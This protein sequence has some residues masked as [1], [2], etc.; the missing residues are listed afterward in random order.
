MARRTAK[1]SLLPLHR[2]DVLG[3]YGKLPKTTSTNSSSREEAGKIFRQITSSLPTRCHHGEAIQDALGPFIYIG[4]GILLVF[5]TLVVACT[6]PNCGLALL[7][8]LVSGG[9]SGFLLVTG[10]AELEARM[11]T[12]TRGFE[13]VSDILSNGRTPSGNPR[14][15]A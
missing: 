7:N 9:A 3:S 15:D 12:R 4:T 14:S 11:G 13:S 6:I 1:E 2:Q 8:L 10:L 5:M